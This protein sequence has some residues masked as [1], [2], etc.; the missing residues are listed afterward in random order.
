MRLENG[1]INPHLH[2]SLTKRINHYSLIN[3]QF[4][5]AGLQEHQRY[6]T[7]RTEAGT[8]FRDPLDLESD[9]K[10]FHSASG[11]RNC[12]FPR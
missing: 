11:N 10:D 6:V 7:R 1:A 2:L 4:S 3:F 5:T 8:L 12:A 9:A